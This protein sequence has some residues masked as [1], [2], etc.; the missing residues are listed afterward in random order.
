MFTD[1]TI[2]GDVT[3]DGRLEIDN[4]AEFSK[5]MRTFKPGRVTVTVEVDRPKR[6]NRANRYYRGGVLRLISEYTGD[7]SNAL[8]ERFKRMFVE[9]VI[10]EVLGEQIAIYSTA[11]NDSLEFY[12][13]VQSVR[14]FALTDLGVDTPDP[15]PHFRFNRKQETFQ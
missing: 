1:Y 12:N 4:R 7:D 13:F 6:S 3:E 10:I 14:Q 11:D 5:A 15:D 8:H 9:P 2:G